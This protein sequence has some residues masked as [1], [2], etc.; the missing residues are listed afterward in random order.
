MTAGEE[1]PHVNASAWSLQGSGELDQPAASVD[2]IPE[3]AEAPEEQD[4][5]IGR[6][7]GGRYQIVGYLGEGGMAAVYRARDQGFIRRDV[8]IK[9]LHP[10]SAV[11]KST[12]A[13]FRKEAQLIADI[14]HP[15]VVHVIDIGYTD[16]GHLYLVM[17]LME[18][19]TL[20]QEIRDVTGRGEVFSWPRAAAIT[21]Q[22]CAALNVAHKAKVVH[23]D[24]KPSNC[25]CVAVEGG[26]D[27]IKL[28][29]FGIA[30]VQAGEASEDSLATPLT[31]EGMFL[32][33]PHFAAPEVIV[34]DPE[35]PVD[36]RVDI[37]AVGV[38][39]YLMITGVLP[40][41]GCS[42]L[43]VLYKTV[44][45][46]P[47]PP[48]QRAPTRDISVEVDALVMTS[49][50][51]DPHERF[52]TVTA[53]M[54]AIRATLQQPQ[55]V[56]I[57][58][59]DVGRRGVLVAGSITDVKP[60]PAAAG[61][62]PRTR[63]PAVASNPRLTSSVD[64]RLA[65]SSP[66]HVEPRRSVVVG[67]RD[68]HGSRPPSGSGKTATTSSSRRITIL[69]VS[70]MLGSVALLALLIHELRSTGAPAPAPVA[71][72]TPRTASPTPAP[73]PTPTKES[74][75][76]PVPDGDRP[77]T[78]PS[79]ATPTTVTPTA[80]TPVATPPVGPTVKSSPRAS[81]EAGVQKP[82]SSEQ[83]L[84]KLEQARAKIVRDRINA[85]VRSVAIVD[86]LPGTV[87]LDDQVVDQ[88]PIYVRVE[89]SGKISV[90]LQPR[91]VT[92]RLP[93][94]ADACVLKLIN[95]QSFPPAAVT[96][97]FPMTLNID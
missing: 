2:P 60:S 33:T 84:E 80:G 1:R 57:P 77:P 3:P 83:T 37:F 25:F 89:T 70:M 59:P 4:P 6:T 72:A 87:L 34:Q 26:E 8:A 24:I 22:I 64:G 9:L 12:L 96:A 91:P 23:R 7:V 49:M 78:S 36:G 29:D 10:E 52:T 69:L 82:K 20:Q 17:E 76:A 38:M 63:R 41:Q 43:D 44:H 45:E 88:L 62:V 65:E 19:H 97:N 79:T 18:G 30:K 73:T 11:S 39:M 53:L 74:A 58:P 13:R 90:I 28:L 93:E 14:R 56:T 92:R 27:F 66:G 61:E 46:R 40:F 42:K 48:R 68:S 85:L 32:G 21:L 81:S 95:A 55:P 51:I 16:D 94:A 86:C 50:A 15:N 31:Q 5:W 54:A 67:L 35:W 47:L 75:P 71:T